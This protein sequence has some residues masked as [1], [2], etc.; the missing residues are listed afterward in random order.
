MK[1]SPRERGNASGFTLI[2]L[3]VVIA[4]I[5]IL[6]AILFPVFAQAREKARAITCISNLKQIGLGCS[7]YIQDYDE[8]YPLGYT[9]LSTDGNSWG[10]TMWTISLGPY[11]QKYGTTN[12]EFINGQ[13][14]GVAN[15]YVCPSISFNADANGNP[16]PGPGIG[17]GMN[18]TQVTTGWTG[19]P[20]ASNGP[21]WTFPGVTLA[22]LDAPSGLVDFA[23]EA[24]VSGASD[25]NS[26]LENNENCNGNYND[27]TDTACGPFNLHPDNWIP[28]GTTGWN[29]SVPG[30]GDYDW[31]GR[32]RVPHFRHQQHCNAAFADGHAKAVP[33]GTIS[34]RIGTTSDVWH[35]HP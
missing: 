30:V 16:M 10:G 34:A 14:P 20:S 26:D 35:N 21:L 6:A 18:D 27:P 2:E 12:T 13:A 3:L 23:D 1:P 4:I 17:Y 33:E 9:W 32:H 5:A 8:T 15:I 25:P 11:I 24:V 19:L 7:M 22:S 31:Y 29:F 28:V